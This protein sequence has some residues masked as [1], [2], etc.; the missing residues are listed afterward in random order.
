MGFDM[1]WAES[2]DDEAG[3]GRTRAGTTAEREATHLRLSI[4]E[5]AWV[6]RVLQAAGVLEW[7]PAGPIEELFYV[8]GKQRVLHEAFMARVGKYLSA[9]SPTILSED[10]PPARVVAVKL[11]LNDAQRL[12]P[13]ECLLI[14]NT[15][16][17]SRDPAAVID[18]VEVA[19]WFRDGAAHGG[20]LVQ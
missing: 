2:S 12:A 10:P 17:T 7:G 5:M 18:A 9:T 1:R 6:R 3:R 16:G 15:L 4:W 20:V 14:A 19:G 8:E 13:S 11:L